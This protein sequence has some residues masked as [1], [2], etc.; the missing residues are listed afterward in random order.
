MRNKSEAPSVIIAG[1][2]HDDW[3]NYS[4]DSDLFTPADAWQMSLG[5]P[6]SKTPGWLRPWVEVQVRLGDEPVMSGRLD[7]LRRNV[8]K[9]ESTLTLEGRDG[10]GVLLDCSAPLFVRREVT[11]PEVCDLI[12]RPL[13]IER[14]EVR[15]QGTAFGKITVEPGMTAWEALKAAAEK[16]G[17]W[18]WFTPDGT[19]RVAAPD[20]DAPVSAEL[21]LEAAAQAGMPPSRTNVLTLAVE[22][23]A[24]GRYDEITV[25]GQ[26]LGAE[27]VEA[28][29]AVR[30]VARDD[31]FPF[32]RP[33]IRNAGHVDDRAH[34]GDMARKLLNDGIMGS[35]I[36]TASVYG[37]RNADGVLW[38]PGQR[39][40]V[41][42]PALGV[43]KDMLLTRRTFSG[44]PE[45][46]LTRLT[47]KPWGYWT[48]GKGG[49]A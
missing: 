29:N 13:G 7:T 31:D 35:L 38:E 26:S 16:A 3:L 32:K 9:Q 14:I 24:A 37:H 5:I 45:G 40:H 25:L 18:P 47:L 20:D 36:V 11:L 42:A 39:I 28:D 22:E 41:H 34:A 49:A 48:V 43:D 27:D 33:L 1:H 23:S 19:L 10:A 15:S 6:W 30:A 4:L 21:V 44:G 2:A 17:L 12:V 8:G 46:S